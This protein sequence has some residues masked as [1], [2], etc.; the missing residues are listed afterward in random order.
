MSGRDDDDPFGCD[1]P[2]PEL[3]E[4]LVVHPRHG[5]GRCH[6][7]KGHQSECDP[8]PWADLLEAEI[9][10][11]NARTPTPVNKT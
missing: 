5:W 1:D 10:E 2:L 4:K 3:C 8:D 11:L 6:W 7:P 9:A